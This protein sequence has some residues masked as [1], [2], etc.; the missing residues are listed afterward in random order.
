[1]RHLI[2]LQRINR[3]HAINITNH[4]I[5]LESQ[6][7]LCNSYNTSCDWYRE[8]LD[9]MQ[10][11]YINT[12][13]LQ[14]TLNIQNYVTYLEKYD[15][16]FFNVEN[17]CKRFYSDL[18]PGRCSQPLFRDH[19]KFPSLWKLSRHLQEEYKHI[20]QTLQRL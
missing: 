15:L 14:F 7:T 19:C 11:M 4:V 1:M 6:S 13:M 17:S 16:F 9:T 12:L 18:P 8:S 20:S 3:H 5:G 2:G 10:Y